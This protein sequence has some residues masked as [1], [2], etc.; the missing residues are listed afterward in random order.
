MTAL[1]QYAR[2]EST[3]LWRPGPQAQRR[4]VVVSFGEAT[5]VIADAVGRPL[6]HWSLPAIV[7]L[8]AAEVPA[9]YSPDG[10]TDETLEIEDPLMV[11]AI[12]RVRASL[13]RRE[14]RPGRLR[15][16][17][18][19]GTGLALVLAGT[20]WLPGALTRQAQA[21]LSPAT[22]IEIG[23]TLLGHLQ[24]LTGPVCQEP[25]GTVALERLALRLFGGRGVQIVVVPGGMAAARVLPGQIVV[26]PV[27]I[28]DPD[29][30]P[31]AVAGR[32][33]GAA[34]GPGGQDP[35]APIL[36]SIGLAGTLRVLTSGLIASDSLAA[37]AQ[38][39]AQTAPDLAPAPALIA[40]FDAADLAL[41]PF[42][43]ALDPTGES[44]LP[45]IEADAVTQDVH[46]PAMSDADWLAMQGICSV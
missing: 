23:A 15:L 17:G 5:L 29:S 8:T 31:A 35:L 26:L 6:A 36:D 10:S 27:A 19:A 20:L 33:V 24:R 37:Q 32:I 46:A 18:F 25:R 44:V 4:E 7:R 30:D 1:D 28:F 43:Y 40:A 42:A 11:A 3:G 12:D 2:L 39:L 45:L 38:E 21:L 9:T 13:S 41:S 34:Q 14:P 16:L 22:R